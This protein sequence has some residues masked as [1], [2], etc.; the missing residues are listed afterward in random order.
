MGEL[1]RKHEFPELEKPGELFREII[2]N[3]L[4]Q[5][6]SSGPARIITKRF[7][8]LFRKA[9]TAKQ[10]LAMPDQRIRDCGTSWAKVKYIKSFCQAVEDG[11]LDLGKLKELKDEEVIAELTKVKGIG[12][13]TAEMILMFNLLRPDVFSLG[14]LGLRSAIAELYGVKRENF[15]KIEKITEKW[16][17]FRTY[18]ALYLWQW[19]DKP[20]KV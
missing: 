18:A 8:E 12:R 20:K 11:S 16:K 3:I 5:Q 17:P 7:W 19:R 10:I 14:D 1:V 6:L 4:G 15:K 2:E 13:W 9:P